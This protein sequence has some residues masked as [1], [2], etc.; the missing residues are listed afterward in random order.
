MHDA[1]FGPDQQGWPLS[2]AHSA[3]GSALY[4]PGAVLAGEGG[5]FLVLG[6]SCYGQTGTCITK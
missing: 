5:S 2:G 3:W 6:S 4:L 1:I